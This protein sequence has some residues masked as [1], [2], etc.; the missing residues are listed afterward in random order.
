MEA[1]GLTAAFANAL[2]QAN[3]SCNVIAAYFHDHIFVSEDDAE[4]ALKTLRAL[5]SA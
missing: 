2:K 4:K 1:A 5:K 3:S